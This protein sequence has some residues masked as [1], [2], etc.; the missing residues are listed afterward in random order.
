MS[1]GKQSSN[2]P[3]GRSRRPQFQKPALTVEMQKQIGLQ[4]R[5]LYI[6]VVQ[7]GVLTDSPSSCAGLMHKDSAKTHDR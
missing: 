4:L 5:N 6:G 2:G 1:E 3:T 7:E